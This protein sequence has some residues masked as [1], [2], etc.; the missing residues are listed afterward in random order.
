MVAVRLTVY[1]P[2]TVYWCE[3]FLA[4]EVLVSPKFH[5]HEVGVFVDRSVKATLTGAVPL[6]GVPENS[7]T[8][9]GT[10][11]GVGVVVSGVEWVVTG[12]DPRASKFAEVIVYEPGLY[13]TRTVLVVAEPMS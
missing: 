6:K 11:V 10:D 1:V 3:G 5:A 13:T 12:A 4:V 8:G 2:G 7:A 9:T